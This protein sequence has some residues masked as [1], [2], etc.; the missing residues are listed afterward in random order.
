M[1]TANNV[2]AG[3]S[4]RANIATNFESPLPMASFLNKYFAKYRKDSKR[5][6]DIKEVLNPF[7]IKKKS[8]N[9]LS[10]KLNKT[11]PQIPETNP[12]FIKP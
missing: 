8:I 1:L 9:F 5:K 10:K 2:P 7:A 3:P 12:K 6:N 4:H 11:N